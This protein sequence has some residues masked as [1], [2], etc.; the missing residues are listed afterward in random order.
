MDRDP[1][2][3]TE[4]STSAAESPARDPEIHGDPRWRVTLPVMWVAQLCSIMGFSFVM[5]FMPFFVR[6]LGVTEK[7]IPVWAGLTGTGAGIAMSIMGPI[8]GFVADRHGRK[9]MVQRAMFGGSIVLALM[10]MTQNVYQLL[11]L[12]ILQGSITGTVPASVALVSS[13]VPKD[14]LGSSLGLMQMA[15][16]MGGSIGPYI[17]GI[18]ADRYGYRIPFGVTGA[19][20][21]TGGILVLFGAKERFIPP[22]KEERADSSPLRV[23]LRTPVILSL[24]GVFFTMNLSMSLVMPIFPLFV[25]QIVGTPQKA[26]SETGILLA[27]TGVA[28]A[29]SALMAGRMS[30]RVG[31]KTMLAACTFLAA[32]LSFPHFFAQSVGQLVFLRILFGLAAGGMVPAMN[33]LVASTVP[34]ANIGQAYGF[35][36]TASALG[37]A[38]GPAIGG[39][40]ASVVG[41][42]WPFVIMGGLLV[43]ATLAQ[44]RWIGAEAAD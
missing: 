27:V 41:Y 25:E 15:V 5:P 24:L 17:G 22:S 26:A 16:F 35:T 4:D 9:L 6:E 3:T 44:R 32:L 34:R 2:L 38:T 13:V 43:L 11:A 33:A 30:D 37:W 40:A 36:T 20:L 28:A 42:R 21:F 31:H 8:W 14:R 18:V 19:L 12:R 1:N 10:G 39:L 23:L 29:F 7:M